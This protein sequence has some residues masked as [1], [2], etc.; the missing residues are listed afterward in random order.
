MRLCSGSAEASTHGLATEAEHGSGCC[1]GVLCPGSSCQRLWSLL[2]RNRLQG[3]CCL[4]LQLRQA[5]LPCLSWCQSV[6]SPRCFMVQAQLCASPHMWAWLSNIRVRQGM[7]YLHTSSPPVIHRDLKYGLPAS[8]ALP[9]P[10]PALLLWPHRLIPPSALPHAC[11]ARALSRRAALQVSKPVGGQALACQGRPALH[12]TASCSSP[13]CH[14]LAVHASGLH[15][16]LCPP[17]GT[18]AA[19]PVHAGSSRGRL[20]PATQSARCEH[21]CPFTSVAV[22]R[23]AT[24]TYPGW[25]RRPWEP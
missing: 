21:A 22:C 12:A 20:T 18:A 3:C 23:C 16:R 8:S 1:Q 6:P 9:E 2:G 24:S 25:W 13:M 7:L 15:C 14:M 11:L 17:Q 19:V 5:A 4:V 10:N